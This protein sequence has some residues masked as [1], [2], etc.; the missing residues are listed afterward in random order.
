MRIPSFLKWHRKKKKQI[1]ST[2]QQQPLAQKSRQLC[3][4]QIPEILGLIFSHLDQY[5]L[6]RTV[7]LVCRQ[8]FV[9]SNRLITR[10]IVCSA[11]PSSSRNIKKLM[12]RV[13]GASRI[14]VKMSNM[15]HKEQKRMWQGLEEAL[16]TKCNNEMERQ[17]QV[18]MNPQLLWAQDDEQQREGT[19]V[20]VET[21]KSRLIEWREKSS[22]LLELCMVDGYGRPSANNMG[23]FVPF[24]RTL[25]TLRLEQMRG[26][27][28]PLSIYGILQCCPR[29]SSLHLSSAYHHNDYHVAHPYCPQIRSQWERERD[30][31]LQSLYL[32]YLG[33]PQPELEFILLNT[34]RLQELKLVALRKRPYDKIKFFHHIRSLALPLRTVHFSVDGQAL[35]SNDVYDISQEL[36]PAIT[37]MSFCT[38]G[39]EPSIVIALLHIP[40]TLTTLE[41]N[42]TDLGVPITG[43]DLH[44]YLCASPHLLHLRALYA[45]F[46]VQDLVLYDDGDFIGSSLSSNTFSGPIWACRKLRTLQLGVDSSANIAYEPVPERTRILFGYISRLCP[47]L[48]HLQIRY[49]RLSFNLEGGVCL[50]S[51]LANLETLHLGTADGKTSRRVKTVD[52]DW[53]SDSGYSD[54]RRMKRQKAV[55]G[56]KRLLRLESQQRPNQLQRTQHAHLLEVAEASG[57]RVSSRKRLEYD[58]R[59][60]GRLLDIKLMMDELNSTR[61]SRCW[62]LLQKICLYSYLRNEPIRASKGLM[63]GLQSHPF[64]EEY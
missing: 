9:V 62:P 11:P 59:N 30:H 41:I 33:V 2:L 48:R 46:D 22:P 63:P 23:K 39:L 35:T 25:T 10:E 8:W 49:S 16:E 55:A 26:Y 54:D 47:R 51:R 12:S 40:N 37:G 24:L 13:P 14:Y 61:H 56:W 45:H 15:N 17:Q 21:N 60:L 43:R 64:I 34:P 32:K 36:G 27:M 19:L 6:R 3:L 20:A 58:L 5:T 29:L 42:S 44:I 53:M 38:S 18:V 57:E 7:N 1:T 28:L 31:P 50:L 4:F 52:L